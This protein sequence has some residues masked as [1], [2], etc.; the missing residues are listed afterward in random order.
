M[1][2]TMKHQWNVCPPLARLRKTLLPGLPGLMLTMVALI[3]FLPAGAQ[4][5]EA[6]RS[7][8]LS[9]Y[10]IPF[11]VGAA[12]ELTDGLI[13]NDLNG[14]KRNVSEEVK[15][16]LIRYIFDAFEEEGSATVQSDLSYDVP[17]STLRRRSP[18]TVSKYTSDFETNFDIG[19][20]LIDLNTFRF[21][22]PE[23]PG[24]YTYE[25][26]GA[27]QQ[28]LLGP[29]GDTL[30]DVPQDRLAKY[31]ARRNPTTRRLDV[32][33][34]SIAFLDES[35]LP[36]FM[37]REELEILSQQYLKWRREG[38]SYDK[39]EMMSSEAIQEAYDVV[40]KKRE[41]K[42]LSFSNTVDRYL[43]A[44]NRGDMKAAAEEFLKA[45]KMQRSHPFVLSEKDNIQN[46]LTEEVLHVHSRMQEAE[47]AANYPEA[48]AQLSALKALLDLWRGLNNR[49]Y[50][51]ARQMLANESR[52]ES[53]NR[54]WLDY[55]RQIDNATYRKQLH[56]ELSEKV[57]DIDCREM[58][59][60]ERQR[61]AL[62]HMVLGKITSIIRLGRKDAPPESYFL[63]AIN[64]HPAFALPKLELVKIL[65]HDLEK[66]ESFLDDLLYFEPQNPKY[67]FRRG[68]LRYRA[69]RR[70]QA[71]DDF[72]KAV[73]YDANHSAAWLELAKM[74]LVNKEYKE[75]ISKLEILDGISDQPI[76]PVFTAYAYLES[77]G[78]ESEKAR[79]AVDQFKLLKL[80]AR[81]SGALDSLAGI[82]MDQAFYHRRT[83]R[84]NTEAAKKYEKML[85]LVGHR[86]SFYLQWADA[87]ECYYEMGNS[88]NYFDRALHFAELSMAQSRGNSPKA[89]KVMGL[90]YRDRGDYARSKEN[91]YTLLALRNDFDS[92]FELAE[93]FFEEGREYVVARVY[94]EKAAAHLGKRAP[95]EDEYRVQ[96]RLCQSYRE[97]GET[98]QSLNHCKKTIKLKPKKGEGFYERGL[99]LAAAEK[100][101]FQKKSLGQFDD[102]RKRGFDP[103]TIYRVKAETLM[104]LGIF[105]KAKKEFDE[106]VNLSESEVSPMDYAH[107]ARV[108]MMLN[109]LDL[110]YSDLQKAVARS[111]DFQDTYIYSTLQGF[112]AL[113]KFR[114]S[115]SSAS[116]KQQYLDEAQQHFS[117]AVERNITGADGYLGLSMYHFYSGSTEEA[118]EK[119][120]LAIGHEVDI[121]FLQKDMRFKGYFTDRDIK[122]K[123]KSSELS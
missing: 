36:E 70:G 76:I 16:Q 82:Y 30:N 55:Q 8:S 115:G 53:Q 28:Y 58:P 110:A 113:K 54:N 67:F 4:R 13:S 42:R 40:R 15:E 75:A 89:A 29:E 46:G 59:E 61:L 107:R 62:S 114:D 105:K 27:Y 45:E 38:S 104:G 63:Q 91:L 18:I 19:S 119:L 47:A 80:D 41:D 103:A 68:V 24:P 3:S 7:D 90:L 122:Q 49:A 77:E 31:V 83:S 52:I 112:L 86:K 1:N 64:C 85:V 100:R 69:N 26:Y 50:D 96:L 87:A 88:R 23:N 99:T 14:L 44:M 95:K 5:S 98:K 66:A 32:K 21:T 17:V 84:Q 116:F 34:L 78:H 10:E 71:Y 22:F 74:D 101:S 11:L 97:E 109:E 108:H 111:T 65:E 51:E 37:E 57:K 123:L 94:Y 2:E 12:Q 56:E 117:R 33:I 60:E 118:L 102:A 106:L 48:A 120:S 39:L 35:R 43:Q 25:M 6:E 93:T 20:I 72:S 81:A 9:A 92:N 73:S 79:E 121:E